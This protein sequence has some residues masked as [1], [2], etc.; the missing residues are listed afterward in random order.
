[1]ENGT[2]Y[3][4]LFYLCSRIRKTNRTTFGFLNWE[5]FSKMENFLDFKNEKVSQKK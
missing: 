4:F 3:R 2:S 5:K 1:M